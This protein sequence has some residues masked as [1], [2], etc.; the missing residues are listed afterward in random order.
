MC[1]RSLQLLH[2]A[3]LKWQSRD[4]WLFRPQCLHFFVLWVEF[5]LRLKN[6]CTSMSALR[7]MGLTRDA[8]SFEA[9]SFDRAISRADLYVSFFL[10][11][12][13][14]GAALLYSPITS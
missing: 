3:S 12:R 5:I 7:D 6:L 10:V 2:T 14:S 13:S 11:N 8:A 9:H 4:L 1:P